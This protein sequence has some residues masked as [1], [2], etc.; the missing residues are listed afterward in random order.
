FD[1]PSLGL[2]PFL[3]KDTFD[4][5]KKINQEGVTILLVE[6][7]VTQTLSMCDRAVVLENGRNV[8]EGTGKELMANDHVR[9]AY[10]GI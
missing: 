5:I 6:Q 7:N 2:A 8:L 9:E 1:E 4:L 3:V 10:L